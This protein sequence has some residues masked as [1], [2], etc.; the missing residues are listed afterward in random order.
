MIY[1]PYEF[2]QYKNPKKKENYKSAGINYWGSNYY[3]SGVPTCS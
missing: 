1:T 3:F 2:N